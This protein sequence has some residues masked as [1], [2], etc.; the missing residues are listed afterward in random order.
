MT[1]ADG[2]AVR[3]ATLT[4][5]EATLRR[6]TTAR[7]VCGEFLDVVNAS[8]GEPVPTTSAYICTKRKPCPDHPGTAVTNPAVHGNAWLGRQ[9]DIRPE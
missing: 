4:P 9:R 3:R 2:D 5:H 1:L 7:R 8:G 6:G